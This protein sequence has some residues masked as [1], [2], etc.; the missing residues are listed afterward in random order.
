MFQD[1]E[2]NAARSR[3]G[4]RF[5]IYSSAPDLLKA[6]MYQYVRLDERSFTINSEAFLECGLRH[7]QVFA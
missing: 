5:L 3:T 6:A 4:G 1:I 2:L 7:G